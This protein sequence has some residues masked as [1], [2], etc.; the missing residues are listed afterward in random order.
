MMLT[1]DEKARRKQ[2]IMEACFAYYCENGLNETG[3]NALGAACGI[4][5]SSFYNY[6]DNLDDLIVQ[7]T[8]Y[9]M[10]KVENEFIEKAVSYCEACKP[11]DISVVIRF[12]REVPYWTAQRHAKKYRFMYQVY[13]S[14][15]Y[16]EY[17]KRFFEDVNVR[18]AAYAEMLADKIALPKADVESIIFSVVRASV[19]FA[20]FDDEHYLTSQLGLIINGLKAITHKIEHGCDER[21]GDT[22]I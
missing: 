11:V 2:R 3:I 6:F 7:S 17:G 18:Y 22:A 12:I 4:N 13:T 10:A 20:M 19:H 1:A 9:C 8:A 16:L 21:R 5:K 14:P 15:K